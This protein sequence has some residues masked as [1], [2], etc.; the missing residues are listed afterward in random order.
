MILSLF[1][2]QPKGLNKEEIIAEF[3]NL[4]SWE[5]IEVLDELGLRNHGSRISLRS[6]SIKDLR[7]ELNRRGF[8]VFNG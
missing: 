2:Y 4:P 7:D 5:Q 3:E 6:Y 1:N 8:D